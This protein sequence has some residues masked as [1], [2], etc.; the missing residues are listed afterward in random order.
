MSRL[1][2]ARDLA[3][4]SHLAVSLWHCRACGQAL[5]WVWMEFIDWQGGDDAQYTTLVPIDQVELAEI[6]RMGAALDLDFIGALGRDRR[7]LD[8]DLPT[9]KPGWLGGAAGHFRSTM[10]TEPAHRL[11]D[12]SQ[13]AHEAAVSSGRLARRAAIRS[14]GNAM[15]MMM[16]VQIPTEAGN[17]AIKDGSL[18]LEIIQL[19]NGGM[20]FHGGFAGCIAAVVLFAKKRAASRYSR[21]ATSP[22]RSARSAC[23][24][25]GSRTSSMA[26]CGAA[27][28]MRRGASYS[29][30][31]ERCRAIRA[32][33]TRRTLEGI[34]LFSLLYLLVRLGAL[35]GPA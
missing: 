32:S 13:P 30:A 16:T 29:R 33:S 12:V 25:G 19:W 9:R 8:R 23:C 7:R 1:E 35:G 21:S 3:S 22:A 28:P 11:A 6:E 5:V 4:E 17:A 24:S 14:R 2:H 26:S 27:K 34:V 18:P 15:R 31:A 10:A 20:S